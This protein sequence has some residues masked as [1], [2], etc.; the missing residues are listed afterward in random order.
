M[1]PADSSPPSFDR[2][3]PTPV[4]AVEREGVRYAQ[5]LRASEADFGQVGGILTASDA[6]KGGMLWSLKV[7]DNARR[8]GLEGDAQDVFFS[9][10]AFDARGRL[11]IENERG[12]RFAVDVQTRQVSALP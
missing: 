11:V 9:H 7:Y 1:A 8:P 5:N 12:Q 3:G 6:R 10:M 4:A 2:N